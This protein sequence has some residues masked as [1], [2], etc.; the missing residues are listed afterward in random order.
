MCAVNRRTLVVGLA[1]GALTPPAAAYAQANVP[2]VGI[3]HFAATTSDMLGPE[4]RHSSTA[5]FLEGMRELGYIYGRD[6]LT[7]PRGGEGKPEL[8][9]GQATELT[10]LRAAVIVAAGPNLLTLTRTTSTIPIVMA[11]GDPVADAFVQSLNRPGGNMTG[12][13]LQETD[14][15]GKRL[16]LLKEL[17]PSAAPVVVLWTKTTRSSAQYL[18]AAEATA[19]ARGW[20]LLTLEV[21]EPGDIER[22]FRAATEARASALLDLAT[23]VTFARAR[24]VAELAARNRLPAIYG[25][26]AYV[27]AGGLI[28]YGADIRAIWR[29][30]ATFVTKILKGARPGDLPVEQPTQFELV[31]NLK[32]AKA[33][34]VTIP[35]SLLARA[36]QVIE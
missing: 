2:R 25:L 14:T 4:P 23:G 17:V 11:A 30:S 7:E 31:I 36:D 35:P 1:L 21:R 22:A 13:T 18:Q 3:L 10:R 34:G 5:A 27:E 9:P 28:A 24:Q 15:T 20:R 12:L 33:I 29:R 16:E 19:R 6:F 32:A 8:W 26:R